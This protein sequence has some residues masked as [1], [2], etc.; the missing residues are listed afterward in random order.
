[1]ALDRALGLF[2]TQG[3][4]GTSIADLTEALDINPP[5]LYAAFGS[6]EE[7]FREALDLYIRAYGLPLEQA[8]TEEK[9]ALDAVA[10]ILRAAA[11]LFPAGSTPGGCVICNGVL[12]CAPSHRPVANV[13]ADTRELMVSALGGRITAAKAV[14]E[15]PGDVDP[16]T[17]ARFIAAVIE[18]MAVQAR[19]GA[20]EATLLGVADVALRAW[21]ARARAH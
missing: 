3:F 10:L 16:I 9:T 4:E 6:K 5:S 14:G 20:D 2:W 1:V 11:H 13:V 18:G 8:L 19:D 15:I 21:P 17:L 12:T 7:L